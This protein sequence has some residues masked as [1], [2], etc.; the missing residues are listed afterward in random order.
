MNCDELLLM[1]STGSSQEEI[2]NEKSLLDKKEK[3]YSLAACNKTKQYLGT[4]LTVEQVQQL[5]PQ[6]IIKYFNRYESLL[7]AKMVKSLGHTV[8]GLYAKA[9]SRVFNVDSEAD[10]AYDLSQDPILTRTLET[11][12]CDMYYRFGSLLAPVAASM[13]TLKHIKFNHIEKDGGTE[14]SHEPTGSTGECQEPRATL[15]YTSDI[16]NKETWE[17]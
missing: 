10:L 2:T 16:C 13:I 8:I 5:S 17:S 3:L 4:Q 7:G 1:T 11:L 9:T 6:D 14:H 12:G 15:P